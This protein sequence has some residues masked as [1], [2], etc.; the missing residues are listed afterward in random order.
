MPTNWVVDD[1]CIIQE[2][3][4]N[5]LTEDGFRLLALEEFDSTVWEK[6]TDTGN[7]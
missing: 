3:G 6:E 5:L 7:G 1:F 4:G 2:T